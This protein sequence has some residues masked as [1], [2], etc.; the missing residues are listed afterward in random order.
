MCVCVCVL[1]REGGERSLCHSALCTLIHI[2]T[3]SFVYLCVHACIPA[4]LTSFCSCLEG[5]AVEAEDLLM[6]VCCIVYLWWVLHNCDISQHFATFGQ[7]FV[8]IC[9]TPHH[10]LTTS[11]AGILHDQLWGCRGEQLR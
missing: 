7:L 2:L 9:T 5:L 6:E 4:L 8:N 10:S 3:S 1:W 11:L